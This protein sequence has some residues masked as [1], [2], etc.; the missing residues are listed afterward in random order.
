MAEAFVTPDG[1]MQAMTLDEIFAYLTEV[2]SLGDDARGSVI[3]ILERRGFSKSDVD[4]IL[5]GAAL[6]ITGMILEEEFFK[7]ESVSAYLRTLLKTAEVDGLALSPDQAR[8]LILQFHIQLCV[9]LMGGIHPHETLAELK[10]K[11]KRGF[12]K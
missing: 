9:S 8:G 1:V 10:K 4:L 2:V 6:T 3:A 11:L 7:E 5:N 12:G